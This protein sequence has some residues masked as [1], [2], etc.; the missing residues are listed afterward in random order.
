MSGLA[1]AL[2][3]GAVLAAAVLAGC[4]GGD[5][6]R[7][8]AGNSGTL[9]AAS[10]VIKIPAAATSASASGRRVQYVSATSRSATIALSPAQGCVNCTPAVSY[11]VALAGQS[12][13]CVTNAQGRTCTLVTNLTAGSYVGSIILYNGFVNG[14]GNATGSPISEKT[15][16]PITVVLGQSNVTGVVLDGVPA[17]LTT[18]VLTPATLFVGT[19]VVNG[20]PTAVYRLLGGGASG[21]VSV[22]AKD[23][24]GN[25]LVG[26]GAPA[27]TAAATGG[28]TA[29]VNGS[30]VTLTAPA[31]NAK[32]SGALTINAVSSAC[33]DPAATCSLGVPVAFDQILAVVDPGAGSVSIW[34]IGATAPIATIT[35]G[36]NA[37]SAVAFAPNGTLFVA[38]QGNSTVT[39]YA[40]PY[41]NAPVTISTGVKH[42]VSLAVDAQNEVVV[43]NSAGANVTI[44]PPPYTTAA[45]VT[46]GAGAGPSAVLVSAVSQRLWVL[47]TSGVLYRYPPPYTAGGFDRNI[48]TTATFNGP[49]G[50]AIDSTFRLY[51]ANSGDNDVLRFDSPY[52]QTPSATI[53]STAGAPMTLPVAV[54]V[55]A[56]DALLAGSQDGLDTY[57]SAGAPIALIAGP[58][59][60]PTGMTIDQDGMVWAA[61]GSGNGVYGV[62]PPYDGSNTLALK[63]NFFINPNAVAV[64]P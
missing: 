20:L 42:P 40:P 13:A 46:L 25:L 8:A 3:S 44:Y 2:R 47:S 59:Y 45:P 32:Q 21:Q 36:I 16:F 24:D 5:T 57:T 37:P 52:N 60:K 18:A 51:V 54:I 29:S 10:I 31:V 23:A 19:K 15:S 28:F 22:T 61:T 1:K 4:G 35:T 50:L 9:T 56:G 38:N 27:F 41:T 49:H 48:G 17:S 53:A 39:A 33:G 12:T 55:G 11:G 63:T 64:Y 26:A 34:P 62:P 58:L 43:A 7:V 14:L 6:S 30:T